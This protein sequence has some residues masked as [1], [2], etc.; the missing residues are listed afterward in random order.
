MGVVMIKE[1]A[2]SSSS[3]TRS[4]DLRSIPAGGPEHPWDAAIRRPRLAGKLTDDGRRQWP[5]SPSIVD[6]LIDLLEILPPS[7]RWGM[8]AYLSQRYYDNWRPLR[9]EVA[10][11][12]ALDVGTLS[13]DM[14]FQRMSRHAARRGVS[15]LG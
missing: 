12:I 15:C 8:I 11:L 2:T 1:P 13:L 10:D 9:A 7:R 3:A 14:Y 5:R 6:D 4:C